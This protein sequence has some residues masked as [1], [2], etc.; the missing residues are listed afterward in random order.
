MIAYK[1]FHKGLICRG[2]QFVLGKNVTEKANCR[3]NG[4]HCAEDPLD[5]LSYYP[6]MDNSEYYIVDAGGDLDEDGTDT[7]ISCTEITVLKRLSKKEFFLHALIYMADHPQRRWNGYVR[8]EAAEAERGFAIVRGCSPFAKGKAGDILALAK[9]EPETGK[10]IQI[11]V[12]GVDGKEI[13]PGQWYDE[14]LRRM[15][16]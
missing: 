8:R 10:I 15:A 16:G 14:N 6:D 5:C 4:F 9:E 1:G 7:K 11:A 2:Y 12:A 13:L 3:E